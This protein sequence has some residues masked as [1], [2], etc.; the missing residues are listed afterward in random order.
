MSN[1]IRVV[2]TGLGTVNPLAHTVRDYW[3]GLL[4]GRSGVGPI[5]LFD[6][7]A[8]KVHF[9]GEVHAALRAADLA[10]FV[11]SA[12]DGVEVG[13]EAAWRL[14]SELGMPRMV[15]VNKLDRERADFARTLET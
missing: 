10:V 5:T 13:T 12:V 8:F 15:F 6:T 3:A 2:V 14:A 4:A 1:R 7:A 9:A 11:V